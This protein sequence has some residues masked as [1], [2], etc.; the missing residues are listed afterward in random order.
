MP[1]RPRAATGG[2]VYHV[3]NRAVGR[4]TILEK[5]QDYA[6]FE[7]VL[8]EAGPRV[9]MRLLAFCLMPNHWHLVLWPREDGDLSEYMRW[10]TN[11]HTRRWH[12][13]HRTVGTGPL[14]Q[15]RF[16]SFPV[17][18]DEH[19]F[20]VC[21]YVERNALRANLVSSAQ[22][23]RWCSLWHRVN[24]SNAISLADWPLARG[25]EWL[26]YVNQAETGA[27]LKALRHSVSHGT[28]FG[29][30]VW[31]QATAR[32]LRLEATMRAPG[33][34]RRRGPRA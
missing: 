4:A 24:K 19:F 12:L 10:L 25:E 5:V 34:P 27:E 17:Q 13:V 21:R 8:E 31:Q 6:A 9:E 20:R 14:Y 30:T 32:R 1:R 3:L 16:R 7:K 29:Q 15:G 11:T 18:E 23:W 22:Q 2:Y 26:A 33:R 28:P